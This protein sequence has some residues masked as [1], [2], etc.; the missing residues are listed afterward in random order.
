MTDQPIACT[1]PA[2]ERSARLELIES[3]AADALLDRTPLGD[4]LRLR[5][6]GDAEA[7]VRD[8]VALESRC[9]AFLDFAIRRDGDVVIVD[10]I[11]DRSEVGGDCL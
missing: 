5:F 7:R 4:G 6:R 2:A 10:V 11:G 9:C 1:L 3:L 8:V